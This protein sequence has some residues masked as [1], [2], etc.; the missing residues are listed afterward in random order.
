MKLLFVSN[1][2][3]DKAQPWRGLD[4]ATLLHHLADRWEI[5]VLA[6]RPT[7]PWQH[8]ACQS[9]RTDTAL[10]P[11]Y[12]PSLYVPKF[13]SRW[14]H[15]LMAAALRAPL[16]EV[17]REFAFDVVLG[18]WIFPDC[19][20]LAELAQEMNFPLVAIAQGSD[21]HQYL[22]NPTRREIILD[23]LPLASA[24]VTRS[25]ELARLLVAAG[26]PT[27]RVYPIYN[28]ID[29]ACFTPADSAAA[30]RELGLP[31]TGRL[32]LF[33]GNFYDIKNPQLL[34]EAHALLASESDC[35]LVLIGDGPLAPALRQSAAR[36]GT[37]ARVVFA[38]RKDAPAV[39]RYM[40][41][42][43]VLALP[44]RNEGVPNVILEAFACGLP[45]VASKV[46]GI[47]EVHNS[48]ELGRLFPEGNLD[49]LTDALRSV[50]QSPTAHDRIH[51]H[52]RQFSWERTTEAYD[53]LLRQAIT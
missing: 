25:G 30:R 46:G 10:Q 47:P 13:G 52:A 33:V 19:C 48:V 18:S 23:R 43:D 27:G 3:P 9:R 8:R 1:L 32:I 49:A 37:S 36:L 50:L 28:G 12:L 42:A 26:L 24:V 4:N 39:A 53:T 38:G 11:H 20:A 15:R 17:Q 21:V 34:V 14:N 22:R 2:F 41:A 44:S 16:R 35:H 45:V 31:E 6:V 40:Q 5:R 29:F 51:H 7:L